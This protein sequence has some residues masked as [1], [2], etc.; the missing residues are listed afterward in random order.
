MPKHSIQSK[1][2]L[3]A[4]GLLLNVAVSAHSCLVAQ[5]APIPPSPTPG[6]PSAA[7]FQGSVPRGAAT[8]GPVDL[9][10]DDAMQ[11]GLQANLGIILSG[12]QTAG[13]RAQRLSQLQTLLPSVDFN[14]KE[15]EMQTDLPAEGLRIPGF[16]KIIG[17]FSYQDVRANMTWSLVNINSLRNYLAARHNFAAAQLSAEDARDMV[18]LTVGNAY[19]LVLADETEVSSVEAQVATAKVSLDQAA[20]NHQAGTAPL[21]DELRARVDY[22]S[23]EQQLIAARNALEKD[24]LALQRTIGMPLEQSFNL[25]DKAPFAPF[26]TLDADALIKQAKENRKDLAALVEVAA[27]ATEQ[28]KA[29]TAARL[30]TIEADADYGDIGATLGHSHGTVDATGTLSVPIF[31]EFA[32]RGQAEQAQAQLDTAQAQL[33]DKR[34]QVDA[35]VRDAL[36]DIAAAQKQVEVAQ[37]SRDLANE[38]L[39]EAQDRYANGVSDNL[40]VS[41]AQ[42]S[43]AQADN[44]YVA[45][46]YR[47]NVAKLSLARALG[48]GL[49]YRKYVGGK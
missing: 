15:A 39:K 47:H 7:S 20:A 40:A 24:K 33:S 6:P 17:P 29:A 44:E 30:P 49:D 3:W 26:D 28:R 32:L 48:A 14:A 41:Q 42:Q 21:L 34:A 4:A 12:T 11:R 45:S 10:L 35:D 37:S 18:V 1:I 2:R 22:Q 27:A 36:L 23:L 31:D 5:T 19:L 13:A 16:P 8:A 25:T 43:V 9:S 38:A 46:L